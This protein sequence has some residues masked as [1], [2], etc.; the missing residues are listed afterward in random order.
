MSKDL[1][2]IYS[3][4]NSG[5]LPEALRSTRLIQNLTQEQVAD[6]CGIT[7]AQYVAIEAGKIGPDAALMAKLTK[8]FSRALTFS[9]VG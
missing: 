4:Q 9:E 6:R 2:W 3:V 8:V 7:R 1:S 5:T